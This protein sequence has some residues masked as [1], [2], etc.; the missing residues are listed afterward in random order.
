MTPIIYPTQRYGNLLIVNAAIGGITTQP[1]VLKLLVDTGASYTL[2]SA[3]VLQSL[4]YTLDN[5]SQQMTVIAAGG[6]LQAP[7]IPVTW[8]NCLGQSIPNFSA[9]AW[10]LPRGI[11]A[12][13]LLGMDFLMQIGAVIDTQKGEI[14]VLQ[15]TR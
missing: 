15:Q 7:V 14:R 12:S 10:N 8:F 4:G 3:K 11:I 6:T 1:K 9:L 2:L 13:G 5:P